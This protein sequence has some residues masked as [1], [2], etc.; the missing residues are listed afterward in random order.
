MSKDTVSLTMTLQDLADLR[1]L[2]SIAVWIRSEQIENEEVNLLTVRPEDLDSLL[3]PVVIQ[4]DML[5]IRRAKGDMNAARIAWGRMNTLLN[6]RHAE[7]LTPSWHTPEDL[8]DNST[9]HFSAPR[10]EAMSTLGQCVKDKGH[11]G[12]HRNERHGAWR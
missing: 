11:T 2:V 7:A 1:H 8:A 12:Y 4:N 6:L 3:P 10:C 5:N 9:V